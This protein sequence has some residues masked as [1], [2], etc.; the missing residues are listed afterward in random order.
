VQPD[1]FLKE[2]SQASFISNSFNLQADILTGG[3]IPDINSAVEANLDLQNSNDQLFAVMGGRNILNAVTFSKDSVVDLLTSVFKQAYDNLP[4]QFNCETYDQ[5]MSFIDKFGTHAVTSYT[6]G[7]NYEITFKTSKTNIVDEAKISAEIS[8]IVNLMRG[9]K[10]IDISANTLTSS[11]FYFSG[12]ELVGGDTSIVYPKGKQQSDYCCLTDFLNRPTNPSIVTFSAENGKSAQK[13]S[14]LL[15]G[16]GNYDALSNAIDSYLSNLPCTCT[17][18]CCPSPMIE[19]MH[20]NPGAMKAGCYL[21]YL[22]SWNDC[23]YLPISE[24][25]L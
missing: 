17:P 10:G 12:I 3:L 15:Y 21:K 8:E 18:A 14:N 23:N 13:I 22:K 20:Y 25:Q 19:Y 11:D 7:V 2:D 4:S 9:K 16:Y 1:I 6:V 24:C 5:F